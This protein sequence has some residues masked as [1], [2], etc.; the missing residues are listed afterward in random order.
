MSFEK[1]IKMAAGAGAGVGHKRKH[2]E[3]LPECGICRE[4]VNE[5][6]CS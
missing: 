3:A 5:T 6:L 1:Q 4:A 2:A